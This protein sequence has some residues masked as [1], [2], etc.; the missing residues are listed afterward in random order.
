M[1]KRTKKAK[2]TA[3]DLKLFATKFAVLK[4]AERAYTKN[5]TSGNKEYMKTD[6][7]IMRSLIRELPDVTALL[8]LLPTYPNEPTTN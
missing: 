8:T 5:E 3:P 6:L 1:T 2:S 7:H 4:L